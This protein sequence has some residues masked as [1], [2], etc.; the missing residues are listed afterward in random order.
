MKPSKK[1]DKVKALENLKKQ[2]VIIAYCCC[3]TKKT[4][5]TGSGGYTMMGC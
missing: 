3:G 5:S 4:A 2:K 1:G